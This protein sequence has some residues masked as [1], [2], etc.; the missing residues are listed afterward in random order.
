MSAVV[1]EAYE[2][3]LGDLSAYFRV[4]I[5]VQ[6]GMQA[7]RKSHLAVPNTDRS[8]TPTSQT[9]QSNFHTY[10][11][12]RLN[13]APTVEVHLVQSAQPPGGMGEPGTSAIVPLTR[14][15]PINP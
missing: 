14:T 5:P 4:R 13:E 10:R 11:V 12:L 15:S 3:G 6:A 1:H 9:E 2:T 8:R 7:L